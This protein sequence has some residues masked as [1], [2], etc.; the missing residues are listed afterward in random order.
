MK[1]VNIGGKWYRDNFNFKL[2][3]RYFNKKNIPFELRMQIKKYLEYIWNE[4]KAQNEEE[5]L[6]I[7]NSL[8]KTLREELLLEANGNIV[9]NLPMFFKNFGEDV[10]RKVVFNIKEVRFTPGDIIFMVISFFNS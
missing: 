4:E 3:I 9:K 7:I 6:S 2:L 1:P 8:S 5:E 10:L